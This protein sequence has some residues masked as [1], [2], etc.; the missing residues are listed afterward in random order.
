MLTGIDV[1]E[2]DMRTELFGV[3]HASPFIVSP[4]GVQELMHTDKDIGTARAA[5]SLGIPYTHSSAA[6]TQLETV[7][8]EADLAAEDSNGWFQLYWPSDD[9]LTES[10]LKRAKKAGFKV[11]VVTLDTWV[12]GWRPKDLDE[13][14]NPFLQG[15][16]VANIL[17]DP[18]FV[19]E[20]CGGKDPRREDA[21]K[22]ELFEASVAAV[23]LLNPGISRKWSEL[24]LLRKLWGDAP[25]VLK[26]VQSL[27]DANRA[28]EAGMDGIWVSNHGG[29]QV[30]GALSS[31]TALATIGRHIRSLPMHI[32]AG[33][34]VRSGSSNGD[35]DGDGDEENTPRRKP[36]VIFDSGVR[37][38]ADA[39]KALCLGADAVAIGR[40]W[41]WGLACNGQEGVEQVFRTL[42]ADLELNMA[43][44]G[45]NSKASLRPELLTR[46]G[47]ESSL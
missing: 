42:A 19:Q 36:Y 44:A 9:R 6:S 29:R 10:I 38:G 13:A 1:N 46:A 17:S 12:L 3:E 35:G 24:A 2:I 25:I 34:S 20:Y 40:P 7:A 31:L 8:S 23:G 39:M 18:F 45:I 14:Y 22:E 37:C 16:G 28:V 15:K 47:R 27:L 26:G 5:V 11:L 30:D 4:I 33:L 21:S 41:I 32:T 43:L